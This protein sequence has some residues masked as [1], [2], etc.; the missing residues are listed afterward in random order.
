MLD[1][2]L[3]T[4]RVRINQ[5]EFPEGIY[6]F[7]HSKMLIGWRLF[8]GK[9]FNTI[10]SRSKDGEILSAILE[11]W[12]Y[13]I[14]RG[15]SSKGGKEALDELVVDA[16]QRHYAALTPD[17]PRGPALEVKNGA[18]SLA[19]KT[20]LPLIPVR[21]NYSSKKI[22]SRS[23]DKFEIPLPF[24]LCEVTI[25]SKYAYDK[26]LDG[27]ELIRFKNKLKSEMN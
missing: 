13:K 1:L 25:G 12:S 5:T 26:I 9:N 6:L 16:D 4:V 23:W 7:W 2:Y 11:R 20:K 21:I 19:Y 18:L 3:S 15:S 22:L 14:S 24:S 10:I 8:R 17:G 27:T